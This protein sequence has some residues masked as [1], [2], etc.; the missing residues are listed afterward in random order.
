MDRVS[1]SGLVDLGFNSESGQ[2]NDLKIGIHSFP[3]CA[4]GKG[5]YR[6][7]PSQCGRQMVG[8]S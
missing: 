5:T 1:A 3:A 6:V 2:T 8:N 7:S 4:V